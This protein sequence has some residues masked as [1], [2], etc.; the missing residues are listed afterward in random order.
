MK[1]S[2]N[3]KVDFTQ[4][5]DDLFEDLINYNGDQVSTLPKSKKN[6][7]FLEPNKNIFDSNTYFENVNNDTI[8][9]LMSNSLKY[10]IN[11]K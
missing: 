7:T 3:N 6:I 10:D 4:D 1:I 2:S 5:E 8:K 11:L 9:E